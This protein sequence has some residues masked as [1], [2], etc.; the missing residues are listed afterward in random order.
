VT[1]IYIIEG[2]QLYDFCADRMSW[3]LWQLEDCSPDWQRTLAVSR[4]PGSIDW[5]YAGQAA[6]MIGLTRQALYPWYRHPT[7]PLSMVSRISKQWIWPP[8]L[9][10]W[11]K[12]RGFAVPAELRARAEPKPPP[13]AQLRRAAR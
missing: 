2:E 3:M 11:C 13:G 1:A 5:I 4:P 10:L 9:I 8:D 7:M 6:Q 12:R